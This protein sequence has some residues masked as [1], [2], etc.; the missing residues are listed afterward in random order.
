M[1]PMPQ[2][3]LGVHFRQK[4]ISPAETCRW[5][6]SAVRGHVAE[7]PPYQGE[8]IGVQMPDLSGWYNAPLG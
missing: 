4:F 7:I 2:M 5:T 1:R 8:R 3:L 6:K